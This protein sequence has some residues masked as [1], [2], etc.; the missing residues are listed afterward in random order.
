MEEKT[1]TLTIRQ[2][3]PSHY[4]VIIPE[5]GA[6]KTAATLESA[7]T[8]IVHD[9]VKQLTT[10]SLVLVFADYQ[11]GRDGGFFEAQ[12]DPHTNLE[13]QAVLEVAHL[14]IAPLVKRK[15]H[16]LLFELSRPLTRSQASWLD[17]HAGTLL[18]RYYTRDEL[19]VKLDTWLKEARDNRKVVPNE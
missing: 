11:V 4:E 12:G 17:E 6:T 15:E 3:G 18:E 2:I 14:G 9:I 1:Y 8:T 5:I 13:Q 19:E 10:R 16:H 7:L